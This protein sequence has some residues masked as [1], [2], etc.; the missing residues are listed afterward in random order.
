MIL[1]DINDLVPEILPFVRGCTLP[2]IR[3][4]IL[5]TAIDFCR[6]TLFSQENI[7]G[8]DIVADDD[9]ILIPSP[10]IHVEQLYAF[11]VLIVGRGYIPEINGRTMAVF[12]SSPNREMNMKVENQSDFPS[13][14]SNIPK[15]GIRV[16]PT[17]NVT[18]LE[19]INVRC[20]YKP[21]TNATKLD[22][23]LLDDHRQAIVRGT[24]YRLQNMIGE[25]WANPKAAM[26]HDR[27]YELEISN[28]RVEVNRDFGLATLYVQPV[29]LA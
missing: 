8:L 6:R 27:D 15:V 28:A 12:G 10:S 9:V 23:T 3:N 1:D 14:W 29:P 18:T 21:T 13:A 26:V 4:N 17:P 19:G 11:S 7:A 20:A 22:R 2:T 25:E 16:Y 5:L 24:L